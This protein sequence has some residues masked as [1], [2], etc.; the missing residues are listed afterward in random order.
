MATTVNPDVKARLA[1]ETQLATMVRDHER[2][3]VSS[4]RA[5]VRDIVKHGLMGLLGVVAIFVTGMVLVA[6][7][8]NASP[9]PI[10][11]VVERTETQAATAGVVDMVAHVL[12]MPEMEE[13]EYVD[14]NGEVQHV[15][16]VCAP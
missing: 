10:E 1:H 7:A 6:R 16:D 5:F 3:M 2:L 15:D 8:D 11:V 14:F 12:P 9:T 13:D 4:Q